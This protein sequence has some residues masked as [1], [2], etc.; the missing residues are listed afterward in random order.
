MNFTALSRTLKRHSLWTTLKN[1]TGFFF[2]RL[3]DTQIQEVA[4]SMTLTTLLSLIPLLAV[5]LAV[6]AA[7]PSFASSRA[8]LEAMIDRQTE[9]RSSETGEVGRNCRLTGARFIR[10]VRIG[11][12]VHE[13]PRLQTAGAGEH[14][15][16]YAVLHH[17]PVARREHI[18][19]ALVEN[20]VERVARHVERHR[21]GAGIQ[22]HVFEVGH[23]V[24]VRD[25]AAAGGVVFEVVKH[26]VDLVEL[27]FRKGIFQPELVAVRLVDRT[28]FV[29]PT[30]PYVR[31]EI[32][33]VVALFLPDPQNFVERRF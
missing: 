21:I 30:V 12:D 16:Q 24:H 18:L 10:E 7:F 25:D 28:R 19:A 17:V 6:F 2:A 13:F 14:H 1:L 3:K 9:A 11:N 22:V 23:V 15:E 8:A 26:L 4:S 29:C 5:S 20:A 27:P 32:V 31:R 33:N